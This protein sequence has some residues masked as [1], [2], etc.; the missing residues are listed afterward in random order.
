M[1]SIKFGVE[2]TSHPEYRVFAVSGKVLREKSLLAFQVW[3]GYVHVNYFT[4]S[5][6]LL[7]SQ[8]QY[9]SFFKI[10][11]DFMTCVKKEFFIIQPTRLFPH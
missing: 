10:W 9:V 7:E 3:D 11:N 6:S 8:F 5:F 2:H 1:T 4:I